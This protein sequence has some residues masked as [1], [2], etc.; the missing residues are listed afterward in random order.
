MS[1]CR[2][3]SVK[4]L[5]PSPKVRGPVFWREVFGHGTHGNGLCDILADDCECHGMCIDLGKAMHDLVNVHL[6]KRIHYSSTSR[7]VALYYYN[8]FVKKC[9]GGRCR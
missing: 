5:D 8:T 6:H 9:E 7:R 1:L 3:E 4:H 2:V